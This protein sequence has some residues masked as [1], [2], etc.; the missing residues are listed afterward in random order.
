MATLT[1]LYLK[2][3]I[4]DVLK[5]TLEKKDLKGIEITINISDEDNKFGQNV[6]AYVSQSKQDREEKKK[7]FYIGN[8]RVVWTDY[9]ISVFKNKLE[10][11]QMGDDLPF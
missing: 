11:E 1:T 6:S 4:I 5:V 7:R 10:L 9:K 2:K 3:E 8:G